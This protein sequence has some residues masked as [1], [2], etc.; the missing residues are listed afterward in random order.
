M[1]PTLQV[2]AVTGTA[3]ITLGIS[4]FRAT[5]RKTLRCPR[6]CRPGSDNTSTRSR[7]RTFPT[8]WQKPRLPPEGFPRESLQDLH[9]GPGTSI[10]ASTLDAA[11][12]VIYPCRLDNNCTPMPTL[13]SRHPLLLQT[14]YSELM[15]QAMEQP[16]LLVGTPGSVGLR[17]V[18]GHP[19]YYRQYYDAQGKKR[20][21]YLGAAGDDQ[22]EARV[23]GVR[24]QIAVTKG[25]LKEARVLAQQGYVRADQRTGAILAALANHGLFRAGAVLVGSH[26]FGAL[27]NA[28]GVM[29]AAFFTEDVDIARNKPPEAF[30]ILKAGASGSPALAAELTELCKNGLAPYKYP[31]W[32]N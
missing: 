12:V 7:P 28:V 29:G 11:E 26:A 19:F 23:A 27:L 1:I 9:G 15:R 18:K 31:R 20:A 5:F 6:F 21:E 2:G 14:A 24:D 8:G 3:A 13:F 25:L 10:G 4:S 32:I 16:F 30:V 22:A 17:D